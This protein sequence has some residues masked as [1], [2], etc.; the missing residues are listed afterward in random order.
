MARG[1][2]TSRAELARPICQRSMRFSR[3]ARREPRGARDSW[4]NWRRA[5]ASRTPPTSVGTTTRRSPRWP[6]TLR[7][8]RCWWGSPRP[9][10]CRRGAHATESAR[11]VPTGSWR[12][13]RRMAGR[14]RGCATWE[15]AA[16]INC[17]PW[18]WTRRAMS[19]REVLP[20]RRIFQAMIIRVS[21]PVSP[22]DSL[23]R[24]V[25][26][27]LRCCRRGCSVTTCRRWRWTARARCGSRAH[28]ARARC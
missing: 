16:T 13:S 5:A 11:G 12:R 2:R 6:W 1:A 4:R 21:G 17:W 3:P 27:A 25:R 28:A 26:T 10:I 24:S 15:A 9:A 8:A 19:M 20:S 22:V 23:P 14:S 18:R 7:E